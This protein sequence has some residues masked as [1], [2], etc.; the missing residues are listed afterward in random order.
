MM[1]EGSALAG[2]M[3]QEFDRF[4]VIV[5]ITILVLNGCCWESLVDWIKKKGSADPYD[6]ER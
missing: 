4:R 3:F 5:A 2:A 6:V 1:L